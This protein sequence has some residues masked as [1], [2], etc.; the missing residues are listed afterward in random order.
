[1]KGLS[2][3][4]GISKAQASPAIVQAAASASDI[5]VLEA[6]VR[7]ASMSPPNSRTRLAM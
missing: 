1:M 7:I 4:M 6:E 2:A 5:P 3:G